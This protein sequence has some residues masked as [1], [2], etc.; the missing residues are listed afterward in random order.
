MLQLKCINVAPIEKPNGDQMASFEFELLLD[1]NPTG[2]FAKFE[3]SPDQSE[4]GE[5]YTLTDS[6]FDAS[7]AA[8]PHEA[9]KKIPKTLKNDD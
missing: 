4:L 9:H 6:D 1:G 3:L 8:K 7:S 2:Q 5:L